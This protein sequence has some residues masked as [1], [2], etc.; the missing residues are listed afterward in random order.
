MSNAN[1]NSAQYLPEE[2]GEPALEVPAADEDT[3]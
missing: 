2:M 1:R 3:P